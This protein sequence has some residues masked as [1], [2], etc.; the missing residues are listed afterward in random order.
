M[1]I[2]GKFNGRIARALPRHRFHIA[3]G[4]RMIAAANNQFGMGQACVHQMER[5]NH[6]FEP[7]V[8]TPLAEREDAV[9]GI[10]PP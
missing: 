5:L 3:R 4:L 1:H 2:A 6:K 7:F 10:A 8:G 9:L